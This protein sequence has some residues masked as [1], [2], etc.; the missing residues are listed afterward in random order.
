MVSN[1]IEVCFTGNVVEERIKEGS[2]MQKRI[3]SSFVDSVVDSS[4]QLLQLMNSPS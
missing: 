1:K 4:S 2:D 3:R